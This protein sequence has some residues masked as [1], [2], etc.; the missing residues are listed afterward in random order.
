MA[1]LSFKV[2]ADYEK[3]VKLREEISKLENQMKGFNKNTPVIEVRQVEAQL[4][5]ARSQFTSLATEAAR[6]G[7]VM[8]NDFKG[9]I[10][11]ATQVVNRLS[12]EIIEQKAVVKDTEF[13][14]KQLAEAYRKASKSGSGNVGEIGAE[15]EA[16]KK[17]LAEDKAVLF[18]LN[19]EQAKARLH[20]K[21]LKEEYANLKDEAEEMT[22][23]NGLLSKSFKDMATKVAALFTLQKA[24]EFAK[25]IAN[26]RGEFQQLEVAFET[27]LQSKEKADALMAQVV[28]TA[29]KTPFDLQGVASGAK[30]L[31]AYGVASEKVNETLIR[32][33]DIASGL[34]IPLGDL[35]YL[36][37][38][39]MAQGRMYT[40]DLRQ[41]QGRGIPM[42]EEL[43]K[44]MGVT[45]AQVSELV[46]AGK[47]GFK[48]MEQAI[49]NMTSSGGKFS[50]L[51]E[52]QSK[53]ITGQISNLEDAVDQM[54]NEIGRSQ[55][56]AISGAI[57]IASSLVEN[58]EK[59]GK[60]IGGLVTAYGAYKA[61]IIALSTIK[62]TYTAITAA[63]A[64]AELAS[65]GSIK[66][67]TAAT[68]LWK[69]AQE[70]L[71]LAMAKNPYVL[72]GILIAGLC[73]GIY[74]LVTAKSKEE[75]IY[76]R[77]NKELEKYNEELG[78]QKEKLTE[79]FNVI[80]DPSS[81]NMQRVL[82]MEE[83]RKLYPAILKDMSDEEILALSVA[84]ATKKLNKE[85]DAQKRLFYESKIAE[86]A[87][88]YERLANAVKEYEK[89]VR[90]SDVAR[91]TKAK[92]EEVGVE[93]HKWVSEYEAYEN[94]AKKAAF[95]ELPA[96]QKILSL[97]QQ[98]KDLDNQ[99]ADL[100]KKLAEIHKRKQD[101]ANEEPQELNV[102]TLGT[103]AQ[104]TLSG[105][106]WQPGMSEQEVLD[107]MNRIQEQKKQ[108]DKDIEEQKAKQAAD[109]KVL[110]DKQNQANYNRQEANKRAEKEL[111]K[112][113]RDLNYKVA[114]ADID[115]MEEGYAKKMKQLD[116]ELKKE[117]DAIADQ[118]EELLKKRKAEALSEWLAE[119]S[120]RKAYDFKF[121][122]KLTPE[123]EKHFENLGNYAQQKFNK[124][125]TDV[126]KEWEEKGGFI[127]RQFEIDA[128]AEG[129]D[130][131]KAQRELDNEKEIHDL[132][133][134]R[135]AYIEAA[136]AVHIFAQE[137]E[138]AK[139]KNYQPTE[140]DAAKAGEDFDEI[141]RKTRERQNKATLE[142]EREAWQ[143]YKIEYGN[144]KEKIL[145][146]EEQYNDKIAK[147]RTEGERQALIAERDKVLDELKK[148]QDKA[149]QN[150]FKDPTKMSLSTVKDAIK[151]AQDEIKKITDKGALSEDDILKVQALQEALDRLQ[152]YADSA[153]FAG[154]GDGLDGVV[155]KL[156][157][158]RVIRG[159]ITKAEQD[160]NAK[161][162]QD[163]EDELKANKELL[164]KNLAGVGV[165][166]FTDSLNQAAQ[167]M[168]EIAETAG[169]TRLAEVADQMGSIA[170]NLSAAGQ[171]A[172]SGGWIGAIVGGV[173]DMISQTTELFMSSK[174]SALEAINN[175]KDFRHQIEMLEY[176]V[177]DTDFASIFGVDELG[178]A[179]EA[180]E[181]T[182]LA[183]A[184]YMNVMDEMN[185]HVLAQRYENETTS[186]S[187]GAALF[188]GNW[189]SLRKK[190]SN[191]MKGVL[192][193]YEKGYSQLEAMQVK[194]K[195]VNGW[196]NFW[197]IQDEY[198][199]LKDL[200]P[201]LWGEDGV[202]SVE[203][204]KLFLETNTQLN[205]EQRKQIQNVIDLKEAYDDANKQLEAYLNE[206]FGTWGDD[207][208]SIISDS[209][210]QGVDAWEAFGE[211]GADVIKQLG[212]Q[213][214]YTAFFKDTLDAYIEPL[215][216][217]VGDPDE[218]A[219]QTAAL[220]S[221]L[222]GN[223]DVAQEWLKEYYDRAE[224]MGFDMQAGSESSQSASRKG[225]ETLSEDTGNE[226]VGRAV[227]QYESNL[228]MEESTRQLK[229]SV[230]I[231]AANQVQ[232]RDIAA[233]SR[234]LIA[235][236]YLELQQ[237]RE[238]TGV[239][240][241]EL[242]SLNERMN[243]W[244]SKIK[245]L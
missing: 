68:I 73:V 186:A 236:S 78:K 207:I 58:Y 4:A 202:F 20:A 26:V 235:D 51:M 133:S 170:Q 62:K 141:V 227:A 165:E 2:Q 124:G 52:K 84:D 178:K 100:D 82:A 134:Q 46:T 106:V 198:T 203:K 70:K 116:L 69:Q 101:A 164:A 131:D 117:K 110:T 16:A 192:S 197:G 120:E 30:Q 232:M 211:K 17:A 219:R 183:L 145:Y 53:T 63:Q 167:A 224:E 87:Q 3:V 193:A 135:D 140:F 137:K 95:M 166:A 210:L 181:K 11:S 190:V 199:S 112:S 108:N 113:V 221:E 102:F 28:D 123:E 10:Y 196:G 160:G 142:E 184:D 152:S 154:V 8:E 44:I 223:F 50:G 213:A 14:V 6:A 171:G 96:D 144:F 90:E 188:G 143:N 56:G 128:M 169:D 80:N 231:M 115:S 228:R 155:S 209:V 161:A 89:E 240:A 61:A 39:T 119:D 225:Y 5:A 85:Q 22:E 239:T 146:L 121:E 118:K 31:L 200:A 195:D 220:M 103:L 34:S 136:R 153:P 226:M 179:E 230:D 49:V 7:A 216:E 72:A 217:A 182:K 150:I 98:N 139:N 233:E 222:K 79:L 24:G 55:E 122:P 172:A 174:M 214:V 64:A 177:N 189:A 208:A 99:L 77:V 37:G 29:A 43:A 33:G 241:K 91:R 109:Q 218:M 42:A 41:F 191:E 32:L 66:K 163:A 243:D 212:Q 147:A 237:I 158:M 83:L 59:V 15:Y 173:T 175:A 71:N 57:G 19:Q 18:S 65:V 245:S 104:G 86:V 215:K 156:N 114:Q 13:H 40:M 23:Q 129:A 180:L 88:K 201:E 92:M 148:S 105:A 125:R 187:L 130:K 204:A 151:L 76:A 9:K 12:H 205:E 81:T 138:K 25:Q 229:Y 93:L 48:E 54:F 21:E 185:S 132:E 38:T 206:L 149:Y 157:Q 162:K 97:E 47:I 94:A 75:K 67:V 176:V 159:K 111:E 1:V 60:I 127:V 74:A 168:K 27:M 45:K 238:N 234:A 107:E 35:V 194:T 244:D 242:K 126:N 36:Y